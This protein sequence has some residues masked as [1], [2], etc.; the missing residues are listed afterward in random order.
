M[1]IH[2]TPLTGVWIAVDK[3]AETAHSHPYVF[4][5]ADM[6]TILS[7]V[8]VE[9]RLGCSSLPKISVLPEFHPP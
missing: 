1:P 2:D 4:R 3:A 6:E 5:P 7:G 8:Q 9:E